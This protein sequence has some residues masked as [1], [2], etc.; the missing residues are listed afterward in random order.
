VLDS[1][2]VMVASPALQPVITQAKERAIIAYEQ[3]GEVKIL[4]GKHPPQP[5][6]KGKAPVVASNVDG[7]AYVAWEG[8]G[9]G[10]LIMSIPPTLR[11]ESR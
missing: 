6:G 4:I 11:P 3:N 9:G 7:T 2:E 5:L 8:S 10:I 1:E